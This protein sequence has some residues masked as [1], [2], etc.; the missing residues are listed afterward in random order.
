MVSRPAA[1]GWSSSSK[2]TQF[3]Q[4]F[5]VTIQFTVVCHLVIGRESWNLFGYCFAFQHWIRRGEALLGN[6]KYVCVCCKS[7]CECMY[8]CVFSEK[9]KSASSTFSRWISFVL[10]VNK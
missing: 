1:S 7:V 9:M 3:A 2:Q 5:M 8:V 4:E 10:I 6:E